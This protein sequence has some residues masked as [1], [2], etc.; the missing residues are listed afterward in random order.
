M[1]TSKQPSLIICFT[2]PDIALI[3]PLRE[4]MNLISYEFLA[5]QDAKRGVLI[6]SE[7]IIANLFIKIK[8]KINHHKLLFI[9]KSPF[10][11]YT[12]SLLVLH[13]R[14]VREPYLLIL[15][16]YPKLQLP[17]TMLWICQLKKERNVIYITSYMSQTTLL[18]YGPKRY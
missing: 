13:S 6:L 3:T 9:S 4:G 15:G 11:W 16:I 12:C 17:Y 7:V 2:L 14:S 10:F 1:N 18:K 5:C 8:F